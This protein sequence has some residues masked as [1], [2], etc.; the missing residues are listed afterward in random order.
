MSADLPTSSTPPAL[1]VLPPMP[2]RMKRGLRALRFLARFMVLLVFLNLAN[3]LVPSGHE[4]GHLLPFI[5]FIYS[6]PL[7]MFLFACLWG[8]S[9]GHRIAAILALLAPIFLSLPFVTETI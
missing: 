4:L 6:L 3:F 7:L 8:I 9:R 2:A 5:V 1:S